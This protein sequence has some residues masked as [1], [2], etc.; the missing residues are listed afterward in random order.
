MRGRGKVWQ[1]ETACPPGIQNRLWA[2]CGLAAPQD[3][4]GYF[5]TPTK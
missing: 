1:G 5:M 3:W 4:H 2:G